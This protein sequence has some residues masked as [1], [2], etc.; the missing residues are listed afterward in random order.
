MRVVLIG[1]GSVG[2][3]YGYHLQKGG[4]K[5]DFVVRE[6]HLGP[7]AQGVVLY[8][9]NRKD[10]YTP[11]RWTDFG[12]HG[13]VEEALG[14]PADI[15][16]ICTSSTALLDGTVA[17]EVAE[18]RGDAAV[19][20]LQVGTKVPAFVYDHLPKDC[21]VWGKINMCAW[22]A[23]LDGQPLPEPGMGWWF[24]WGNKL[25]FSGPRAGLI[26]GAMVAGGAPAEVVPDV[27][28]DLAFLGIVLGMVTTPLEVAGWSMDRLIADRALVDLA[29]RS[30]KEVWAHAEKT[31]G[32]RTPMGLRM[33]SPGGIRFIL[34]WVLPRAPVN[35]ETFFAAHYTKIADQVSE[36]LAQRISRLAEDDMPNAALTEV[37]RRLMLAREG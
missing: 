9:W 10:R 2:Q 24:P 15:V 1:A 22:W 36:L 8:P 13:S 32:K 23:P 7:L 14:E 17:A 20:I 28:D 34:R 6:R 30:M 16:A 18:H 12:L 33:L 11:L 25:G 27:L 31:T 37:Y 29:H 4:A 21:V 5:V 35:F 3:V 26:A 19:L